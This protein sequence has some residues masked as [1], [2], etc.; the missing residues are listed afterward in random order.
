MTPP[1]RR[2]FLSTSVAAIAATSLV[3]ADE[4]KGM[5]WKKAYMLGGKTEGPVLPTF[6]MLKEAGFEGVELISPNKLDRDEV[7]SARDK[8]GLVIHG[9][10]GSVHW[11]SPLS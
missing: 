5:P 9:V 4:P 6:Q 2:Q 7:L 10:S 8:T 3:R 1:N 11:S